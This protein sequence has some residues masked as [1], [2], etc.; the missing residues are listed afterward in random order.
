TSL[1]ILFTSSSFFLF[2]ISI[3]YLIDENLVFS[4][5]HNKYEDTKS[6]NKE[7]A[8]LYHIIDKKY[9]EANFTDVDIFG[10][11]KIY[12]AKKSGFEWFMNNSDPESDPYLHNYE[13]CKE[14]RWEL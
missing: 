2:L 12:P 14:R 11:K 10:I 5:Q 7:N 9:Q 4:Q 6:L 13:Y 1:I 3:P 8:S